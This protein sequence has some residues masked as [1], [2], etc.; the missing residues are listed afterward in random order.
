MIDHDL[1]KLV[2]RDSG[3]DLRRLERDIWYREASARALESAN[4]RLASC[5]G[6]VIALAIVG[7]ASVGISAAMTAAYPHR[8]ALLT[9][10]ES[11]APSSL[12]FGSPR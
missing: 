12:L 8:A 5:Q 1:E 9:P 3:V 2:A 4:R 6:L 7:S 11:L 10:G